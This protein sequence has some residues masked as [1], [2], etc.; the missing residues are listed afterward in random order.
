MADGAEWSIG[1]S[2]LSPEDFRDALSRISQAPSD[3]TTRGLAE[4]AGLN[5]AEI[6]A[7]AELSGEDLSGDDFSQF[8]F[9]ESRFV[10]VNFAESSFE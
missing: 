10:G 6:F 9:S 4:I 5:F 7:S 8:V 2:P 1:F 3:A